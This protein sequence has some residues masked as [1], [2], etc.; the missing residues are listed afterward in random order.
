[1]GGPSVTLTVYPVWRAT[2]RAVRG[3][4]G[5]AR[6]L[7]PVPFGAG[8]VTYFAMSASCRDGS[9]EQPRAQSLG[10]DLYRA[11]SLALPPFRVEPRYSEVIDAD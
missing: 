3:S 5:P 8:Y 1:M 9:A 7:A 10:R 11:K 2:K 6:A 4:H